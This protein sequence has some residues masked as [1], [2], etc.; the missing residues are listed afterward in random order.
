[1]QGNFDSQLFVSREYRQ[2]TF[3]YEGIIEKI[4]HCDSATTDFDLTG[5]IV[6][7]AS[8]ALA[9]FIIDN[10]E[11]FQGKVVLELG[12]GA[13]LSG[14]V[15]SR[16]A[17]EVILTDG[18]DIVVELL[19]LNALEVE[20]SRRDR[21]KSLKF[22]WQNYVMFYDAYCNNL[23]IIIGADIMF[24]PSSMQPLCQCLRYMIDRQQKKGK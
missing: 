9:A 14:I 10:K 6:W 13:G 17:K 8:E 7:P 19:D 11:I 15:C 20:E 5:Q 23:D 24:W 1:M 3:S 18:N 4:N 16:F 22:D 21:I 12:A 2:H